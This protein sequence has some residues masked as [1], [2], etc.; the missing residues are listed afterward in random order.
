[1]ADGLGDVG[2]AAGGF[3]TPRCWRWPTTPARRPWQARRPAALVEDAQAWRPEQRVEQ[4]L[5]ELRLSGEAVVGSPSGGGIKR[6][7]LARAL[8]G[9]PGDAALDEPTNHLDI[10]GIPWLEGLIREFAARWW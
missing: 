5:G 4:V 1:M 9:E 3:T 8:V 6:A 2:P 7:A 10:D